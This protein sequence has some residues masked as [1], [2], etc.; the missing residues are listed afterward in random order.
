MCRNDMVRLAQAAS[1][2]FN[3]KPRRHAWIAYQTASTKAHYP[4]EFMAGVLSRNVNNINEITKY[5]EESRKMGIEVFPR[6]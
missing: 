4:S 3:K 2:A 6:C 5:M 1:Y